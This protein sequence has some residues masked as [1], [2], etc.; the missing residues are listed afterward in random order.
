M[1]PAERLTQSFRSAETDLL[2]A[3]TK[4]RALYDHPGIKG[5]KVEVAVRHFLRTHLPRSFEV[6]HGEVIDV[7]GGRSKQ[8]DV[9]VTNAD[10]PMSF[11]MDDAGLFLIEGIA[12]AGEI[13]T[14]LTTA[15]LADVLKKGSRLKKMRLSHGEGDMIT[16][17]PSDAERYYRSPPFFA[18]ALESALRPATLLEALR[19][20]P[21]VS[22]PHDAYEMSPLDAIFCVA[23]STVM[24]NNGDGLGG[25]RFMIDGVPTT[26]WVWIRT[27]APLLE[28]FMWLNAVVLRVT[29]K[30]SIALPYLLAGVQSEPAP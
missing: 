5:D 29:R 9:V 23:D 8:L 11:P 2:S 7:H 12:A 4:A 13:K 28:L 21:S 3:L 20:A 30:R 27:D 16:A 10:Q 19:A 18:I 14:K 25:L 24:I 6:G 1:E 26:G 17:T 22:S 15:E